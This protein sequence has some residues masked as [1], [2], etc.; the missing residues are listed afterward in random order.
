MR[1][2]VQRVLEA[3]VSIDG[4]VVERIGPGLLVLAGIAAGDSSD[5]VA[6]MAAKL[7][8]LRIFRDDD[9]KMNRSVADVNG[10]MLVVSQFTLLADVRKGRRPSWVGA[11]APNQ[12]ERLVDELVKRLGAEGVPV[13][14]G[15]FGA[16][17]QVA[18]VND[19]P[20]TIVIDS[21]QGIIS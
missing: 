13:R 19:G 3:T 21:D 2:V 10:E 1:V 11:A 7:I 9:L 16:S 17:M 20:V 4:R 5:D 18:L 15:V 14:T 6:A 12:A 8:S